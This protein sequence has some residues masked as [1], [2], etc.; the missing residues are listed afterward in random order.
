MNWRETDKFK[1]TLVDDAWFYLEI[2][3]DAEIEVEDIKELVRFQYELGNGRIIPV[4]IFPSA[5]ATTNSD[6]I[7]YISKKES[8][9]FTKA[10]AFVLNSVGQRILA[11]IYTKIAPPA[12]PTKF[13]R[14]KSEA[15]KWLKTFLQ[16]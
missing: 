11:S 6:L 8:L 5:S 9:P 15:L 16:D 7:K 14:E 1:L 13:F 4:L 10:D 12:R 3:Q 2:K